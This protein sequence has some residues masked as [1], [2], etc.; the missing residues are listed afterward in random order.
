MTRKLLTGFCASLALLGLF[1]AL[2]GCHPDNGYT[3]AQQTSLDRLNSIAKYSGGDWAKVKP[4]DKQF[5]VKGPGSG[6][7]GSAKM[8]LSA[9][10]ANQKKQ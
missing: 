4:D 2:T 10:A 7:E 6:N 5:L 8:A 3:P 9:I 1:A